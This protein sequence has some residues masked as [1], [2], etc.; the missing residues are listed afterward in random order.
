MPSNGSQ[1]FDAPP[2]SV[3]IYLPDAPTT[4]SGGGVKLNWPTTPSQIACGC[5]INTNGSRPEMREGRTG[6]TR[7]NRIAF[8]TAT[9]TVTL[10]VGTKMI[11]TDS[12]RTFVITGIDSPNRAQGSIPALSYVTA[13]EYL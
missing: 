13:D 2:H 12:G 6:I 11:A 7:N 1:L 3:D 9:L 10:I 4:D 5:S 8:L